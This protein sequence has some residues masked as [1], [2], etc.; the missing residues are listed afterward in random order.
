MIGIIG[1][2][3]EEIIEL[4]SNMKL[5][6]EEVAA[7]MS[8]FVGEINGKEIVLVE[9]GIGK[10]NSAMCTTIL[11]ERFNVDKIIF[12]GVAGAINNNLEVGDVVI[13]KDL[14][15][16]DVDA[17]A[18]GAK[19]GEIPRMKTS[20]FKGDEKLIEIAEKAAKINI[21][22]HSAIIGR[23]LSGDQFVSSS[24]KIDKLRENFN[25]D[26]V[27]M[28]GASVAQVCYIYNIPFVIIRAISDKADHSA[29][30]DFK[31]FVNDA[32]KNAKNIVLS[33]LENMES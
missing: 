10:V 2:M 18:F 26:C 5:S 29:K 32:A 21:K 20:I 24:E 30:V 6:K 19:L 3:N 22:K 31:T 25:G 16:H 13:S 1:A 17:T 15:Q 7:N 23:I 33:M 8:F 28:E 4:K 9:S 11:I 27:E 12:T 14:I